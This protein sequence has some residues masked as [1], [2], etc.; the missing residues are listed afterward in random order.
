VRALEERIACEITF[1]RVVGYRYE[2]PSEQ[3]AADF[4]ADSRLA[5]TTFDIPTRT[6]SAPIVGET[7]YHDLYGLRLHREQEVAFRLTRYI[8]EEYFADAAG[9]IRPWLF[10]QLLPIVQRWMKECLTCKDNTFPQMLL[11]AQFKAAAAEHIYNSLADAEGGKA[12]LQAILRAYDP[13]G[14]TRYVDFD[15]TRPVYAADPDRSHLNYVVCDSSWEAKLAQTLEEMPEVHSYVKNWTSGFTIPYTLDGEERSYIPDYLL[16]CDDGHGPDDLLTLI[17]EVS[18]E[19]RK[20][21]AAKVA[22]ARNLWVPA[23][24]HHGGFGRWAFLEI[25]D[26]WDAQ[27]TIRAALRAEGNGLLLAP[28]D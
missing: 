20:D 13:V 15:T 1:P 12:T 28:G 22:T 10:P 23:I 27:N 24:N 2:F 4:T 16:R 11:M 25:T 7:V 19:A 17:L 3:L 18:G 21:K 9:Q 26:P 8:L 6:E 5:L 14:S